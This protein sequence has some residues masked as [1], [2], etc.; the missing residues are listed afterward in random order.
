MIF[1]VWFLA[2]VAQASYLLLLQE[3]LSP[4][5]VREPMSSH[6]ETIPRNLW[7]DELVHDFFLRRP[8]SSF[9]LVTDGVIVGLV[10]L[11]H[12]TRL[13]CEDCDC[14]P[15]KRGCPQSSAR[16]ESVPQ[17][18]SSWPLTMSCSASFLRSILP[19]GLIA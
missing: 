13:P 8:F 7:A 11:G 2:R 4:L 16:C 15:G 5:T 3:M 10:G 6:P 17:A 18:G 19:A 1:I 9:P 14:P 12:L